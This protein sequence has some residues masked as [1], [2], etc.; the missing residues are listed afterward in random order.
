ME[1]IERLRAE[2]KVEECRRLY[3][4]L[5][6]RVSPPAVQ[7]GPPQPPSQQQ[8]TSP[9]TP[10]IE[11]TELTTEQAMRQALVQK[12]AGWGP[13]ETGCLLNETQIAALKRDNK[14][15]SHR[16]GK[17]RMTPATPAAETSFNNDATAGERAGG[18]KEAGKW[19]W[20]IN[21]DSFQFSMKNATTDIGRDVRGFNLKAQGWCNVEWPE[22]QRA[23]QFLREYEAYRAVRDGAT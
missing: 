21:P 16:L 18:E 10:R 12:A 17:K 3:S 13:T 11:M 8:Q 14:G 5:L 7:V 22:A 20:L 15:L 1:E 19:I 6:H 23:V 9:H 2:T 4:S